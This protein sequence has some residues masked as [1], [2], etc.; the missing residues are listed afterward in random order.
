MADAPITGKMSPNE[1]RY[2]ATEFAG[3]FQENFTYLK[4]ISKSMDISLAREAKRLKMSLGDAA[5]EILAGAD[6]I[7]QAEKKRSKVTEQESKDRE[8]A[9]KEFSGS[10]KDTAKLFGESSKGFIK[11]A[12]SSNASK[13]TIAA[14]MA[15]MS[16]EFESATR[17]GVRETTN[18]LTRS[19][20]SFRVGLSNTELI[21]L[22][23]SS[24]NLVNG[25]GG[26]AQFQDMLLDANDAYFHSIGSLNSTSKF[27]AQA[28]DVFAR[29]GVK[30]AESLGEIT[31]KGG[32][33][34]KTFDIIRHNT[35]KTF[36][37]QIAMTNELM[38]ADGIRLKLLAGD[39]KN[40]K[41]FI[42]DEVLGRQKFLTNM[43]F[44]AEEA[45]NVAMTL[46]GITSMGTKDR[47]KQ[48]AYLES[49]VSS[50]GIENGDL[51]SRF[52]REG[53]T[54][55]FTDEEKKSFFTAAADLKKLQAQAQTA[56]LTDSSQ[57]AVALKF[58]AL[59]SKAS[60]VL[61]T[62]LK[63]GDVTATKSGATGKKDAAGNPIASKGNEQGIG[64]TIMDTLL[65]AGGFIKQGSEMLS[66]IAGS[67]FLL[68]GILG[69]V[70]TIALKMGT[71]K[72]LKA[73][74]AGLGKIF[75]T[76]MK[77]PGASTKL[78]GKI[79]G[80]NVAGKGPGVLA[81]TATKAGAVLTKTGIPQVA[82][83]VAGVATKVPGVAPALKF[84]SSTTK[85]VGGGLKVIAKGLLPL[86]IALGAFDAAS[87]F[88]NASELLG[89]AEKNITT[90]DKMAGA[91]GGLIDGL[92]FGFIDDA[93]TAKTVASMMETSTSIIGTS[94]DGFFDVF[95]AVGETYDS[96]MAINTDNLL[97]SSSNFLSKLGDVGKE[98]SDFSP[99]SLAKK[100]GSSLSNFFGFGSDDKTQDSNKKIIGTTQTS[101]TTPL[102]TSPIRE[103]S[104]VTPTIT[105]KE[106]KELDKE[107][108]ALKDVMVEL[109]A[110]IKMISDGNAETA[111]I[112]KALL[113][114]S[115][116][117][118]MLQRG[119]LE[120]E[121]ETS[122]MMDFQFGN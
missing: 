80:A 73:I 99:V 57:A 19:L 107:S 17:Y 45:K 61:D 40:R 77:A 15:Q 68:T 86:Q 7:A 23:A 51:L 10:V 69:A 79:L 54:D 31:K 74:G 97:E 5:D 27:A 113:A 114:S 2:I 109:S 35:G 46:Q 66:G 28:M 119:M 16:N 26:A 21:E 1:I 103:L 41:K 100:A 85:V 83:K 25:L 117:Q 52:T 62:I 12:F 24:R 43:N 47:L 87:G 71:G 29:S 116:E 56:D 88:N 3:A 120:S 37:E 98:I 93:A 20:D 115:K 112:N 18:A 89:K 53:S 34:Q 36:E 13:F 44:S 105:P 60:G 102:N 75:K 59:S 76:G 95:A 58:E 110:S 6:E 70:T 94:L 90:A 49:M 14:T 33:L 63:A 4:D 48:S 39:T 82:S 50:L 111:G 22:E 121:E 55:K 84:L 30:P 72:F 108:I 96:A 91:W 8:E 9:G 78:G 42:L 32:Q 64:G 92:T 81:K 122:E 38:S 104:R 67:N 101:T 118:T 65:G 11:D 106:A